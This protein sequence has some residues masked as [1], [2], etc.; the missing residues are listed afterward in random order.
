M[1]KKGRLLRAWREGKANHPAYLEDYA[2]LIL[3]LLDL[4]ETDPDPRWYQAALQLAE[5]MQTHFRDPLGGFFDTGR[6]QDPLIVRP[7]EVQDNAIPSG[8]ALAA[9]ALLRLAAYDERVDWRAQ[10]EAMLAGLQPLLV[11]HPVAFSF[12]L[13]DL[14]FAVGPVRQIAIVGGTAEANQV[15]AMLDT[16]WQTY[17]PRSV[18]AVSSGEA[19][20]NL[21]GLLHD[22]G[23]LQNQVTVY[24]CEG[25]T[26]NLPVHTPDGLRQQLA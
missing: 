13:Q 7:R 26:C 19:D 8:S 17:R 14:D 2:G 15:Q 16:I 20:P 25:F 18:V 9:G 12:W 1:V 6:D 22:R 23:M 11:R 10:A 5:E 21:P 4:Y 24:V 3:A